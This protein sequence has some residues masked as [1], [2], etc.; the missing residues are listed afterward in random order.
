MTAPHAT[1]TSQRLST[2][3]TCGGTIKLCEGTGWWHVNGTNH[4][5][6]PQPDDSHV[7]V[8]RP[9]CPFD[10]PDCD[11]YDCDECENER[12]LQDD[13]DAYFERASER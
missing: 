5:H 11:D 6:T 4:G 9:E 1:I 8:E 3:G 2:C 12:A 10:N 7:S 13:A